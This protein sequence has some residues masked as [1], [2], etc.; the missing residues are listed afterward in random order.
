MR[1]K[2]K[3]IRSRKFL[4][5]FTLIELLVVIAIIALL[6]SIVMPSL[7]IAKQSATGIVCLANQK[8]LCIGWFMYHQSN[9]GYF[10]GAD[11]WG[12]GKTANLTPFIPHTSELWVQLPQTEA[13]VAVPYAPAT[14]EDEKRGIMRGALYPY[15]GDVKVYHCP[16]DRREK[17][18]GARDGAYYR[19][20]SIAGGVNGQWRVGPFTELTRDSQLRRPA[21][22]YIMIEEAQR[23]WNQG[24]WAIDV[25]PRWG[26]VGAWIDTLAIWHNKACTLGFADGHSEKLRFVDK[27][28]LKWYK[29]PGFQPTYHPG[30]P[31]QEYMVKH[32]P[33]FENE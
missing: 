5:G 15:V 20:Y 24:S 32:F 30:S 18:Y 17:M 3:Y 21:E 6:L 27:R 29:T 1:D 16:G 10:V 19:S 28:T 25:R 11:A 33:C 12:V 7:R 14:F 23:G 26:A 2:S 22:R 8:S 31:D 9:R 13:G 4:H